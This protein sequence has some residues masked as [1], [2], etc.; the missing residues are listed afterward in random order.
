MLCLMGKPFSQKLHDAYDSNAR[1]VVKDYLSALGWTV[2]DNPD[3]YGIDLFAKVG[4]RQIGVEVECKRGWVDE[5]KFKSLHIPKR[6]EKFISDENLF[7]VLN[8]EMNKAA[9]VSGNSLALCG[10]ISKATSETTDE[11][12][13]FEI[14]IKMVEFV[15]MENP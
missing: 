9:I 13:F 4:D 10:F 7:F 3:K 15:D 11:D 14:P 5:F 6:K 1:E 2:W 8:S 12:L